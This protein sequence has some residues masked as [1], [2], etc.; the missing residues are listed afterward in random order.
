MRAGFLY[1]TGDNEIS[2]QRDT[3]NNFDS[4]LLTIEILLD[5]RVNFRRFWVEPSL[6]FLYNEAER[7]GYSQSCL[8]CQGVIP[9]GLSTI[10]RRFRYRTGN[11][12]ETAREPLSPECRNS[13]IMVKRSALAWR[14]RAMQ[15]SVAKLLPFDRSRPSVE[16]ARDALRVQKP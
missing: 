14:D 1:E 12:H 11:S 15:P 6:G 9:R 5:K 3:D 16:E 2:I 8:T 7:Q 10:H 4:D 13:G